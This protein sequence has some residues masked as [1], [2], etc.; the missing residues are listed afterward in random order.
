MNPRRLYPRIGL[1]L[2]AWLAASA[3]QAADPN[4]DMRYLSVGVQRDA[5]ND[6]SVLSTLSLPVGQRQWL[7]F[8]GG[9]TR[10]AQDAVRHR[11]GV[12]GAGTGYVGEGWLASVGATH[13]RDGER[14]RQ[15]DLMATVEWRADNFSIGLDGS[16]RDA[17]QQG[18]V[19]APTPAGGTAMVPV[20][21]RVQGAGLG[22]HGGL[23]LGA[24]TRL[25]AGAMH[26]D[27][28]SRTR[29]NGNVSGAGGNDP[30]GIV[31]TLLGNPSLLARALSTRASL[32]ARDEVALSRSVQAGASYRLDQLALSAE[33]LGDQVLDVPGT[34]HTV[35]LKAAMDLAPGWRLAPAVG[36]MRSDEHGGVNF[37]A[38]SVTRA[39]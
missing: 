30:G 3:A 38:L 7:Q 20:E 14:Y 32:V 39:W 28:R 37:G 8:S 33:Y 31:S 34:V 11:A 6:Q 26:Y 13:R 35:Q 19:A 29:Q 5:R 22:L 24:R 4:A 10:V 36:R 25:Y 2:A 18:T 17:R 1:A 23:T 21:Q 12:L 27:L 16:Y 15:T 9:Q